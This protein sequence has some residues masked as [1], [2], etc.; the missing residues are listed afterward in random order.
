MS[1]RRNFKTGGFDDDDFQPFNSENDFF[2]DREEEFG[3]KFREKN[4]RDFKK[5]RRHQKE[6]W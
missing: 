1:K 2:D 5:E 4:L 6:K 3:R